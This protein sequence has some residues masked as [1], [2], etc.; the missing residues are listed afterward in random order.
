[1]PKVR[2]E[3]ARWVKVCEASSKVMVPQ[4]VPHST[5][6]ETVTFCRLEAVDSKVPAVTVR[7]PT[8]VIEFVAGAHEP[9][10]PLKVTW[11][12]AEPLELMVAASPES[13]VMVPLLCVSVP[14]LDQLPPTVKDADPGA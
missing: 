14:A 12:N 2:E 3:V 13:K 5:F 9:P 7:L 4:V 1:M 6:P 10:E 8:I 11:K